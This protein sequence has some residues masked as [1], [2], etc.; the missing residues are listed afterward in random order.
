M[1]EELKAQIEAF[2]QQLEE[3][4][5]YLEIAEKRRLL[6]VLEAESGNP[7]FWNDQTRAQANIAATRH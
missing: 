5:G 7:D 4:Q 3:M 6:D 2:R 1:L